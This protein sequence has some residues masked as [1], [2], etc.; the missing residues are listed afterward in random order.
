MACCCVSSARCHT[1][2][3]RNGGF[4]HGLSRLAI[5]S[6]R[7][8]IPLTRRLKSRFSDKS[9]LFNEI[10]HQIL[11]VPICLISNLFFTSCFINCH[12]FTAVEDECWGFAALNLYKRDRVDCLCYSSS[13]FIA[14][15][16]YSYCLEPTLVIGQG[17]KVR[18][19]A[20]VKLCLI[21][22]P[23]FRSVIAG[24]IWVREY[25]VRSTIAAH[26]LATIN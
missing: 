21:Y 13:A 18:D 11:R 14:F 10:L 4:C 19:Q 3:L 20:A 2:L 16:S 17:L 6:S 24:Y 8:Q 12:R 1:R 22:D 9:S 23:Y 15:V 25:L 7:S 5:V 26:V